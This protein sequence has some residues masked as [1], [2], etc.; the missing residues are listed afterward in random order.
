MPRK[1][2]A[3]AA[4]KAV[5]DIPA[6]PESDELEFEFLDDQED[7]V[8]SMHYGPHGTGKTT[9][10]A[11]MANLGKII[12]V[13]AEGGLKIKPLRALGVDTS[14]IVVF[15]KRG[16]PL[17]FESLEKLFWKIKSDLDADPTAWAGTVW[18]SL[19]EIHKALLDNVVAHQVAKAE[20]AGKERDRFFTDRADYGVMTEQV[21]LLCRRFRDLP[22]HFAITALERRDQ[23]DDGTVHYGPAVTPALQTDVLG[24][25]DVVCHT[26]VVEIGGYDEYRGRF[27]PKGKYTAKDRFGAVPVN[28]IDPT[29]DRVH[30]YI[31]DKLTFDEDPVMQEAKARRAQVDQAAAD[32]QTTE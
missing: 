6:E 12:Y 2:T 15:P 10:V 5:P 26:S 28:L 11:H 25:L 21:R 17:T 27:R 16:T 9:A 29:F 32:E 14:N 1:T 4:V 13:N 8:N 31:T 24:Y 23:D 20:R 3:K 22:C 19:S 7:I 18:D 30:G